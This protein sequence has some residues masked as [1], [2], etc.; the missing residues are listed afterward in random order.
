MLFLNIRRRKISLTWS[1]ST[2]WKVRLWKNLWRDLINVELE[3]SCPDRKHTSH[4][5]RGCDVHGPAGHPWI[6]TPQKCRALRGPEAALGWGTWPEKKG[7]RSR[8][9]QSCISYGFY[10]YSKALFNRENMFKYSEFTSKF[11]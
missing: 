7:L 5:S 1:Q 3:R 6:Y 9:K 11:P 10:Y 8:I 2:G 4:R